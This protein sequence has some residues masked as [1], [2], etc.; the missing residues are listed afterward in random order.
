MNRT[1][2]AVLMGLVGLILSAFFPPSSKA[3]NHTITVADFTFTP[4]KTHVQLNDSVIW[5]W[6]GTF[7]HSTTSAVGSGKTWD[8]GL[9]TSGRYGI[10][11]TAADGPG[12]FPYLC[13]LHPSMKDT[14]FLDPPPACCPTTTGNIDCDPDQAVDISDLTALIDYLYI[15]FSPLCCDKAAN[16]DGQPGVDISDLT[17][18]IDFLYISF[19]PLA[20]CQ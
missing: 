14:I 5:V 4:P 18:L 2:R 1:I 11:I 6:A 10:K 16:T 13:T 9:K 3:T 15:S 12:S 7:S 8:S 19:T 20:P 17:R